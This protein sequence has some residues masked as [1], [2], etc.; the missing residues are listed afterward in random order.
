VHTSNWGLENGNLLGL[1]GDWGFFDLDK[2]GRLLIVVEW[3]SL[4][5]DILTK[6]LVTVHTSGEELSVW[7]GTGDTISIGVNAGTEL[8]ET[9]SGGHS[10]GPGWLVEEWVGITDSHGGGGGGKGST[11]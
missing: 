1:V 5:D 7:W 8:D 6:I 4:H 9:T 2:I 3:L 11:F 10:L